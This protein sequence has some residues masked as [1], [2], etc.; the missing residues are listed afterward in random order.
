LFQEINVSSDSCLV[1]RGHLEHPEVDLF[2]LGLLELCLVDSER[3]ELLGHQDNL[4]NLVLVVIT[5]LEVNFYSTFWKI[6]CTVLYVLEYLM[7][8]ILEL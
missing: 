6:Y 7:L 2:H 4:V 1:H 3:L 8:T 5:V